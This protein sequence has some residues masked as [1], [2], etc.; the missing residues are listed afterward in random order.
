MSG[1]ID[2]NV[3]NALAHPATV[4]L[5]QDY[6]GAAQAANSIWQNREWQARQAAGQA[7]QGGIDENGQYQPATALNL[8]RQAGPTAALAV[9]QTL[10]NNQGLSTA[11]T[12]QAA[13]VSRT[14][15][16]ALAPLVNGPDDPAQ[17]HALL[18]Q[19]ADRLVAQGVPR[20][21]VNGVISRLPPDVPAMKQ[22]IELARQAIL[23]PNSAQPAQLYGTRPVVD[24]GGAVTFP[25]V[26][27][28]SAGGSGPTVPMT[29]TPSE[30]NATQQTWN[31]QTRQFEATPRQNVAPMVDGQGNP[32][33]GSAVTGLPASGRPAPAGTQSTPAAPTNIT[34][35]QPGTAE[36]MQGSVQHLLSAR[37]RANNYQANIYPVEGAISAL[38]GADTGKGGEVLNNIRGYLGDTPLKYLSNFLPSTLS[39]QEKRTIYDEA[40][41]YTTAMQLAA[42]GGTRSNAGQE[43]AAASNPSV[44]ISNAAALAVSKSILAQRRMEQA[45]TLAFN[46]T[47]KPGADYDTFMNTWATNQ[48][49]RGFMADRMKPE[50]RAGV[51][52]QLG[53]PGSPAYERYKASYLAAQAAKVSDAAR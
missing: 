5:L 45:G 33:S 12:T 22:Q 29:P 27:P 28:P 37:D 19:T 4:N 35:P 16:G 51:A 41:K 17:M 25:V 23:D 50:E 3:L 6:Q 21:I 8:L 30:R 10:T 31:P 32:T 40:N 26:P 11:Q 15:A 14:I 53:G 38:S 2:P 34:Q 39:D 43:A 9:P 48:D 49:P 36:E 47:G 20:S 1:S 13:D 44:H 24:T 7:Q 18:G 42:P 46:Q 52:K